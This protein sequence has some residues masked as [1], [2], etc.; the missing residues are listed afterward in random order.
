MQFKGSFFLKWTWS[1]EL[2][3]IVLLS[4]VLRDSETRESQIPGQ[5]GLHNK[6]LSQNTVSENK[7]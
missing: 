2:G 1:D 5:P 4:Q 6:V 3:A 7:Y